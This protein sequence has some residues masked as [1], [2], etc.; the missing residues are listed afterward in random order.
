MSSTK[1]V[2]IESFKKQAVQFR[3]EILET[4]QIAGSGHPGGSL[5]AVEIMISL[6][7]YKLK[8]NAQSPDWGGR[9]Y[10]IVSKGHVTPVVY[11]TLA[12]YGF[13]P[14]EELQHLRQLGAKVQGHPH[15]G[16]LPG[17][18]ISSGSLGQGLSVGIGIAAALKLQG[19]KNR[20]YVMM[21]DGEQEEGSTWE[22]IMAAP[23]FKV[24]NL[25]AIV[26]K[27]RMQIDGA[28]EHVMPTLDPLAEKYK[29]FQWEVQEIDGH[30]PT[31]IMSALQK[32]PAST[33][34]PNVIISHTT[35]GQGVSFMEN[36]DHWHAGAITPEQFATIKKELA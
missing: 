23:K 21:S 36:S 9:D 34:T 16:S 17:I 31:E 11:V 6:Y 27:N 22:A 28:T 1:N 29:A 24:D 12:N 18:E 26:D 30:N 35:R 10:L 33:G 14:K 13:F 2:D 7:G 4:L 32:P 5:S 15:R 3:R 19:G 20:V 25:T 8:H